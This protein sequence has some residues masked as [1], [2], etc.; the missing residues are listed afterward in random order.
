MCTRPVLKQFYSIAGRVLA[1]ST[2]DEWSLAAVEKL[3]E[4]W[5]FSP[6]SHDTR[7]PSAAAVI[8]NTGVE[9]PELP[10]NLTEFNIS[11]D[12]T[13]FTDQNLSY[14]RFESSLVRIDS[15]PEVTV[16]IE[17]PTEIA[18]TTLSPLLSQAF[19]AAL[20]RCGLFEFHSG[21][22]VQ[23]GRSTALL[24]AGASGSGKSTLTSQL[25]AGGWAYLS[26]DTV[27]L[28][29]ANGLVEAQALRRFFALTEETVAMLG[30]RPPLRSG[31][32]KQRFSP[33][34]IFPARQIEASRPS[35]IL[36]PVITGETQTHMTS[37][38]SSETM[39]QL[40][41]FCPW[42]CYDK[43]SATDHL[44]VLGA[45]T[46]QAKGFALFAGTDLLQNPRLATEFAQQACSKN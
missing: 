12:A 24:I 19:S 46:R 10:R 2:S 35:A 43:A 36:F 3:V 7:A 20:R 28:N 17:R 29:E 33:E 6:L 22:V 4:G 40:L 23:P 34:E 21:G 38:S 44:R 5:F 39:S 32:E 1:V 37:L 30:S 8:I 41:K 15:S 14:L 25:A 18:F 9:L 11:D 26:D 16:W 13:C 31:A 45:L 27:L 42:S